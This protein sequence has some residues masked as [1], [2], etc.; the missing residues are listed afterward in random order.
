MYRRQQQ[1]VYT[2]IKHYALT[3]V[4]PASAY[5]NQQVTMRVMGLNLLNVHSMLLKME[6]VETGYTQVYKQQV[7][8]IDD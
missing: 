3:G 5:I 2:Y 1:L 4:S 7:L 6:V 8:Y